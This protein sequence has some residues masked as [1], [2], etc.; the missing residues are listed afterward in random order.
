MALARLAA[1]R[2]ALSGLQ[3]QPQQQVSP[4]QWLLHQQQQ[5]QLDMLPYGGAGSVGSSIPRATPSTTPT[6]SA[7][8]N[9]RMG[10]GLPS[11][12]SYGEL[13]GTQQLS[14][15]GLLD[16]TCGL[17]LPG[18]GLPH[19]EASYDLMLA[20]AAAAA[21]T[22]SSAMG[23]MPLDM[24]RL[25]PLPTDGLTPEVAELL[26]LQQQQQQQQQ[27]LAAAM[28][29]SMSMPGDVDFVNQMAARGFTADSWRQ[30]LADLTA[31][32]T[33]PYVDTWEGG[34]VP[35][36]SKSPTTAAAALLASTMAVGPMSSPGAPRSSSSRERGSQLSDA[37]SSSPP[38][39]GKARGGAAAAA[40]VATGGSA[41][42]PSQLMAVAPEPLSQ[43]SGHKPWDL[44]RLAVEEAANLQ[45]HE[46]L[47][48]QVA[49][50]LRQRRTLAL[51]EAAAAEQAQQ[52]QQLREG[53]PEASEEAATVDF[54]Y[55]L[56]DPGADTWGGGVAAVYEHSGCISCEPSNKLFV[57]NIGW[58]V[59]EEDLQR[60]FSKFGTVTQ[61]KVGRLL[62]Q[63]GHRVGAGGTR[64]AP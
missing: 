14:A 20:A 34:L 56:P 45:Q 11:V 24:S 60:W 64:A 26:L 19:A 42:A 53:Q 37:S 57:G 9:L 62:G 29:L 38:P 10:Y 8:S 25:G 23:V 13:Q 7:S 27:Q 35:A 50:L 59:T 18:V 30:D 5:Q 33:A 63:Q 54:A 22:T 21:S 41:V 44:K 46:A 31:Y 43:V 39:T 1:Q 28:G 4:D 48:S 47:A 16:T 52:Q 58:W 2:N 40:A 17:G 49:A 6:S 51:L 3:Q 36:V 55:S 32:N 15:A 61:V 12:P